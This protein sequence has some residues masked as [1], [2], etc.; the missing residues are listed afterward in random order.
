MKIQRL[1]FEIY[2]FLLPFMIL[3]PFFIWFRNIF[4]PVAAIQNN[5][6]IL[7]IGLVLFLLYNKGKIP[8]PKNSLV[9]SG[10]KLC[11][12]LNIISFIISL[13]LYIPFGEL[14][15]ENTLKASFPN[16]I[17]MFLTATTFYYNA[18]MF[19]IVEKKT[20]IKILNF[21]SIILLFIGFLQLLVIKFPN[22]SKIYDIINFTNIIRDSY[23]LLKDGRICFSGSEPA[24]VGCIVT[25]FILPYL[26]SQV[27]YTR[28]FKYKLYSLLFIVL[29]F[30]T[31]SSTVYTGLFVNIIILGE[32][33]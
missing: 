9:V 6:F 23:F 26:L 11:I 3:V 29:C 18:M 10:I 4:S 30:F 24:S 32:R 5:F 8:F 13:V 22:I 17:Y 7:I 21:L 19:Q 20:I 27:L 25:I 15:G 1:I 14:H 16:I 33:R 2:I 28:I 31:Y 12:V